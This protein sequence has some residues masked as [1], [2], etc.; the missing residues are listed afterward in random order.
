MT[1][2]PEKVIRDSEEQKKNKFFSFTDHPTT[3]VRDKQ[4]LLDPDFLKNID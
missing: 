4:T 3:V 1:D 2:H